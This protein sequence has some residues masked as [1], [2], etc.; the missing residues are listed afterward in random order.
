[1]SIA[2]SLALLAVSVAALLGV[3]ALV[4]LFGTRHG[5]TAEVQRKSVHVAMGLY[6]L[7][8]PLLF[9]ARWPVV[10]LLLIALALMLVLRTAASRTAG[11]GAVIHSVERR[12]AGDIWLALAIG[13]VFLRAGNSYILFALPIAVIAL[14]D[15]AAALTG[16]SYGRSRFAV[17]GGVKSWEGVIAFFAVTWIL[18]MVMLLLLTDVPRLNVVV[19]AVT[20][21][22]F[23]AVVEAASWRGLDN[24]FVPVCVHFFLA[25]YLNADPQAL[26]LLAAAFLVAVLAVAL[27]TPRLGLSVHA[28]RA[29]V[30]AIFLFMGVGGLYG[31]VLP[32]LVFSLH[33]IARHRVRCRSAYAD[34]DCIAI[35]CA[36]GLIWLFVG[37]SVGPNAL[38]LYNLTLAGMALGYGIIALRCDWR[39][40][41]LAFAAA[42]GLYLAL[43]EFGPAH[44]RWVAWLP[45]IAAGS[46]A[47]VAVALLARLGWTD[48]WRA[49]RLAAVA[50]VV[51]MTAYL[52]QAVTR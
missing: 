16:T 8:L 39:W 50:I 23:G 48:R 24:L 36:V 12:S 20:I 51:P 28:S 47:L 33:L 41:A 44:A 3:I 42:F 40:A 14:S 29:F 26:M 9:D 38:N 17:E 11:L 34:L 10:A 1:V 43:V 4:R 37:E 45:W 21:A 15:A 25:G 30:I 22:A 13:F 6:A 35:L 19:L 5:W 52:V 7:A 27:L 2:L 46:L 31:T 49:A 18:A 32:V